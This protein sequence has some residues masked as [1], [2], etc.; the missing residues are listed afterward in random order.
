MN[1]FN[2]DSVSDN[3]Q[4][5]IDIIELNGLTPRVAGVKRLGLVWSSLLRA[6]TP[7]FGMFVIIGVFVVALLAPFLA[8]YDPE[9]QEL[10]SRLIPP[11]WVEG[12]DPAYLLGTDML[13]RDILSRL[14]YGT[15]ISLLVGFV[16]AGISGVVGMVLGLLAGYFGGLVDGIISRLIDI[17]LAFPFVLLALTLVAILGGGLL[18]VILVL[19]IGGW[20]AFARIVRVDTLSIKQREF[21]QA[22]HSLGLPTWRILFRHILPNV[23]APMIVIG[24]FAVST[25]IIYEAALTFLGVGVSAEIPTWGSMLADGRDYLGTGWWISTFPGVAIMITVMGI[26]FIGDWLRD[27]LDPRIGFGI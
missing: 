23:L 8:P 20:M 17:Q 9:A 1:S 3:N 22:A 15:R 27:V 12:S 14:I 25:N 13:G 4:S 16:T 10:T 5:A 2:I 26:N 11:A 6:R 24:S 19:G 7:L 21:I 18:N